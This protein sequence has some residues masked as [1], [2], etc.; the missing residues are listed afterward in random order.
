M[1]MTFLCSY[2]STSLSPSLSLSLSLSLI[3]SLSLSLSLRLSR[4]LSLSFFLFHSF[5]LSLLLS[6]F[7]LSL[8]LFLYLIFSLLCLYRPL[9]FFSTLALLVSIFPPL[10]LT[11]SVCVLFPLFSCLA[12]FNYELLSPTPPNFSSS[13]HISSPLTF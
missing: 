9:H 1:L 10:P 2:F 3:L 6:V 12:S 13:S 4:S 7:S 5:S 11:L 8:F